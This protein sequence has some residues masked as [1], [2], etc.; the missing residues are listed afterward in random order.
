MEHDNKC[1]WQLLVDGR[2]IAIVCHIECSDASTEHTNIVWFVQFVQFAWSSMVVQTLHCIA[3]RCIA[4]ERRCWSTRSAH[5]LAYTHTYPFGEW[6]NVITLN[7]G[8]S[9]MNSGKK[10]NLL[11]KRMCNTRKDCISVPLYGNE[12]AKK[13][14]VC[15]TIRLMRECECRTR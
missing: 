14:C 9:I 4:L 8:S 11:F 10:L 6:Q 1:A 15:D 7:V 2:A 12:S 5:A 13:F 3:L